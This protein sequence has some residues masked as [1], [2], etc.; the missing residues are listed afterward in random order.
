MFSVMLR[1]CGASST[2]WPFVQSRLPLEYWIARSSRAMTL[3]WL[4][5]IRIRKPD[6]EIGNRHCLRQTQ[7]VCA[8]EQRDDAIHSSFVTNLWIASAEPVIGRAFAR[9]VGSQ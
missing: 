7:G 2:P 5:E 3:E 1:E 6:S 9:P 4:F 8:R